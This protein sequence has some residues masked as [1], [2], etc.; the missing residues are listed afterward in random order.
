MM[1]EKRSPTN[2]TLVRLENWAAISSPTSLDRAYE[3]SGRG[4]IVSSIGANRGGLSNGSP[5]TVSL[6]AHTTR[7]TD[8]ATAAA[9]TLKVE[10]VLIRNVSASDLIPGAGIAARWTTTSAPVM[11][12]CV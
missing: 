7:S 11:S 2:G 1:L 8:A 9:K 6:E 5:R 12:S 3:L 4:S 10:T